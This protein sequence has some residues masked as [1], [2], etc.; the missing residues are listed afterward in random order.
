MKLVYFASVRR[1]IGVDEETL[2]PPPH[3]RTVA[4][5]IEWLKTRGPRYA[6]AFRDEARLRAAVNQEHTSFDRAIGPNDEIALF[7][8]V[9][10]GA[11]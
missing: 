6:E 10:G 8:P 1:A 7:P 9:T 11:A 4:A 2:D 3:V 5:L